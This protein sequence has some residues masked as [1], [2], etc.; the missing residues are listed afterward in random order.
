MRRASSSGVSGVVF[1]SS[2]GSQRSDVRG[3]GSR[4]PSVETEVLDQL[5]HGTGTRPS[6][7]SPRRTRSRIPVDEI[8]RAGIA[9]VSTR[10]GRSRPAS[11]AAIGPEGKPGLVATPSR[12]CRRTPS[13]SCQA[14]KLANS[15]APTT[16]EHL[17]VAPLCPGDRVDGV[18]RPLA[19]ELVPRERDPGSAAEGCLGEPVADLGIGLDRLVRG[20]AGRHDDQLREPEVPGRRIREHEMPLVRRVE[21]SAEETDHPSSNDS[22][23]ITTSAP[24]RAPA[25]R[26]ASSISASVSAATLRPVRTKPRSER[27]T[28]NDLRCGGRGR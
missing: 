16:K 11:T 17:P 15:S 7:D 18:R 1:S 22:S 5:P 6:I 24:L 10:S 9:N 27:S 20:R 19:V 12:A 13:G 2:F 14:R 4:D 26:S 25:S 3:R 28:R 8:G 23:P 21:R